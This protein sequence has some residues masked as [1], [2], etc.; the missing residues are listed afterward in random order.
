MLA[1]KTGNKGHKWLLEMLKHT[2]ENLGGDS[3]QE[4]VQGSVKERHGK[5][6]RHA[7]VNAPLQSSSLQRDTK[8]VR[9]EG[10]EGPITQSIDKPDIYFIHMKT[11]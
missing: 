8:E 4:T 6:Q 3:Q 5:P 11:I 1:T 9:R 10:Q 7:T 2:G